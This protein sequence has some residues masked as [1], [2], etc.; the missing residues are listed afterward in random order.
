MKSRILIFLSLGIFLAM[1]ACGPSA[2]EIEAKRIADSIRTAD[3]L[4]M[5]QAEVTRRNDSIAKVEA[6]KRIADSIAA[7]HAAKPAK[8]TKKGK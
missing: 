5:V 8:C 4:A 2:K 6:E 3:S 1:T 7:A